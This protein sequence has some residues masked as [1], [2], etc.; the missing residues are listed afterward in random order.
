MR[1]HLG[2]SDAAAAECLERHRAL[3]EFLFRPDDLGGFERH[4]QGYA[5]GE[6]QLLLDAAAR[7]RGL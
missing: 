2:E 6:A 1:G 5:F 7:A 3:F 4:V